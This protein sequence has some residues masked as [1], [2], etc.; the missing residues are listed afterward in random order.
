[1]TGNEA[2]EILEKIFW[3]ILQ[4]YQKNLEESMRESEFNF[5]SV[6]S[7][8]YHLQKTSLKRFFWIVEK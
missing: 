2:D 3:S 4:N 7:L 8:Y 6:T 5:D 1:M